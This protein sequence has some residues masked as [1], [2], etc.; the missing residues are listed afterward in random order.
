[1][2]VSHR[3]F[4]IIY[5]FMGLKPE[6]ESL[7][8]KLIDLCKEACKSEVSSVAVVHD[9]RSPRDARD[10]LERLT[11]AGVHIVESRG[12]DT[13]QNWLD[14]WGWVLE[15]ASEPCSEHRAVLLPGDLQDVA[16]EKQF[17]A[18]L[19]KFVEA[20]GTPFLV[21]DYGSTK[22]QS[23]KELIDIYGV[24]PLVANWF[25]EAWRAIRALHIRK[26]RSEFLNIRLPELAELL[27]SRAFAYEQTL[28]MLI[29]QWYRCWRQANEDFRDADRRWSSRVG[30]LWLGNVSDEASARDYRGAIDQIERT[31][32]M[33]RHLWRDINE[34]KPPQD[35]QRFR[36]LVNDYERLD[37]RSTRIRDAAR[38]A[39][40]AMLSADGGAE[41]ERE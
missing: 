13:C 15:R 24:F 1:M 31:E 17:F 14:G 41:Y 30:A 33:L 18:K 36:K 12:V 37:G 4:L 22:P 38:L 19:E 11:D 28:N 39:L 10:T 6:A 25:P 3:H 7:F 32:R 23:T 29:V 27:R 34:W 5:P 20:E 2:E 26:A 21:G 16:D 40:W 8:W 35:P 9:K